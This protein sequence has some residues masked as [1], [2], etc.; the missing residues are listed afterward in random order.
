MPDPQQPAA[1]PPEP[2]IEAL[3]S[4]ARGLAVKVFHGKP[5]TPDNLRLMADF[6]LATVRAQADNGMWAEWGVTS[7]GELDGLRC[8]FELREPS[9]L[10]R[11]AATAGGRYIA[12]V[13]DFKATPLRFL[14]TEPAPPPVAA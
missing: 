8:A 5:A 14:A 4:H 10:V 6:A 9:L 2:K 3:L 1:A 7:K 13:W 12:P 11:P